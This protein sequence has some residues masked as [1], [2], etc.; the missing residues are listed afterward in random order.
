MMNILKRCW[1]NRWTRRF[2]WSAISLVTLYLLLCAWLN[3]SWG[4]QW[5]ETA[6]MLEAE[7]ETLDFRTLLAADPVPDAENF[8]AIPLLKDLSLVVDND[9]TKGGPAARRER[10]EAIKLP[11]DQGG[12]QRSISL[13]VGLG[14]AVD[15]KAWADLLRE[16]GTLPMPADS[17]NAARDLLAGLSKYDPIV[18]EL[19]AGLNRPHARW[20]PEWKTRELPE[21]LIGIECPHLLISRKLGEALAL[22]STAAARAG[23]PNQAHQEV[24]VMTRIAHANM[25]EFL[26]GLLVGALNTKMIASSTWELCD[27]QSGT[28]QDFARLESALTALDFHRA[29][30]HVFRMDMVVNVNSVQY[31]ERNPSDVIGLFQV[32][33]NGQ[34]AGITPISIAIRFLPRGFYDATASVVAEGEF[35]HFI[36]PLRDHGWKEALKASVEY[37]NWQMEMENRFWSHPHYFMASNLIGS[38]TS[39]I[40]NSI[41]TQSLANQAVIACALERHRIENGSYPDSLDPLKLTDGKPLPLDVMS[42]KPMGYRKTPDGK[43]ALWCVGFDQKDDG[44]KRTLDQTQPERTKFSDENYSGDWVWDFSSSK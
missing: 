39:V 31:I 26:V 3:W 20:T 38:Y 4:R 40:R 8:C 1:Q 25:N 34:S 21:L 2:A 37:E 41:Y 19:T 36:K 15:L 30:L 27:S 24:L 9:T 5:T 28:A 14:K 42:D 18:Q 22:R 6:Q 43:Y 35:K 44:G 29:A 12:K 17:G 11:Y 13:N 10:L 16:D 33:H 23:E 7:G 32:Q